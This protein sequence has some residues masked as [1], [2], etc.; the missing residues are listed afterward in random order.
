MRF[1]PGDAWNLPSEGT[2]VGLFASWSV[3]RKG[4]GALA[5]AHL[6]S[7]MHACVSPETRSLLHNNE[8]F[9]EETM[10]KTT[11]EPMHFLLNRAHLRHK[12]PA[13]K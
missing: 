8:S 10:Q 7:C 12:W 4:V 11:L 9:S 3:Q 6:I 13:Q 2:G 5:P 1:V